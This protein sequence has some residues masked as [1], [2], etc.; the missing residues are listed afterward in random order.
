M[1]NLLKIFTNPVQLFEQEK[2]DAGWVLPAMT[3]LVVSLVAVVLVTL[4][5]DL[6]GA[7]IEQLK[8]AGLPE[9]QID[10]AQIPEIGELTLVGGAV[11]GAAIGF[12]AIILALALYFYIVGRILNTEMGFV[13]WLAMVSWGQ[14]PTVIASVLMIIAVLGMGSQ[15]DP[16]AYNL[17]ALSNYIPLPNVAHPILG[18]VVKGLDLITFYTIAIFTIGFKVWTDCGYGKAVAIAAAPHVVFYAIAM[19]L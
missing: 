19:A 1:K 17:L 7:Q 5:V 15:F 8:A 10:K 13:D 6:V 18:A 4:S 14:M 11:A 3:A 16:S 9:E 2:E 12:F